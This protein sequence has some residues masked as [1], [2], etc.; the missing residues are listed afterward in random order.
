VKSLLLNKTALR[1]TVVASSATAALTAYTTFADTTCQDT[2]TG[3]NLTIQNGANCA[4]GTSN[5]TSLFGGGGTTGI[6]QTISDLL[7]YIVGAVA[8]IMLIIGGLRYVISQGDKGNVESAKNTILYAV[9][10]IVVA[11]LAYAI[12]GFITNNLASSSATGS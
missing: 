8:V 12:V 5:A 11:I 7:I 9:I 3:S 6:F 10:G 4:K 1:A 2:S